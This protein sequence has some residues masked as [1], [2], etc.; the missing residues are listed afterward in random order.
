[1]ATPLTLGVDDDVGGRA[2]DLFSA[3]LE[4]AD[5]NEGSRGSGSG[6]TIDL[7]VDNHVGGRGV[8]AEALKDRRCTGSWCFVFCVRV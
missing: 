5:Q 7:R 1:M 4:M 8:I 2:Y 3:V 6:D